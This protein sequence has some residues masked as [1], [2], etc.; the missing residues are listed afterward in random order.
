MKVA[1]YGQYYKAEDK[2]YIEELLQ[3]L[4]K[5]EIEFV[6]ENIIFQVLKTILNF[7]K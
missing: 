4:Q 2:I 1:I 3:T 6:I 5:N 7:K